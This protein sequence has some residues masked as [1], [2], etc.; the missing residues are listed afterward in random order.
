L[1]N[2]IAPWLL[3]W[4]FFSPPC[5]INPSSILLSIWLLL[6]LVCAPCIRPPWW[7]MLLY[8]IVCYSK[9]W[10]PLR[11]WKQTLWW[12]SYLTCEVFHCGGLHISLS[13]HTSNKTSNHATRMCGP[14]TY[15]KLQRLYASNAII[16]KLWLVISNK[17]W[18]FY[19]HSKTIKDRMKDSSKPNPYILSTNS[20]L[21]VA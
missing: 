17:A 1:V 9:K 2:D 3:H 6:W 14:I 18:S 13:I 8:V 5:I 10:L 4:S 15:W 19:V 16:I 7:T 20:N 21:A 12:T 11:S